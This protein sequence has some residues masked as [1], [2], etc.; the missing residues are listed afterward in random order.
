MSHLDSMKT[1]PQKVVKCWLVY[2]PTKNDISGCVP[3]FLDEH[4]QKLMLAENTGLF[5]TFEK[6]KWASLYAR[7]F[8][9][10]VV[11]CTISYPTPPIKHKDEDWKKKVPISK[12]RLATERVAKA[13]LGNWHFL[14]PV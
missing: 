12:T 11:P 9:G 13:G 14:L 1:P 4:L 7:K 3:L 2:S 5:S 6:K 10:I 8:K